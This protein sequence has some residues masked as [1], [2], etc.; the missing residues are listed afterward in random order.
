MRWNKM[1][2]KAIRN[3]V[4]EAISI[5]Q[6][7]FHAP[8]IGVP[9]TYLD[10]EVF[11]SDAPFLRNAPFISTMISNPNHIGVHTFE[12]H[13]ME[14][15]FAGT[16]A[17]EI[18]LIR[19]MAENM[20]KGGE[21][22]QDGYVAAGGTEANIQAQWIYR[23]YFIKERGAKIEEIA[24]VYSADSH[25]SMP[26]GANVLNLKSII[27]DV[28][29]N[30][31]QINQEDMH[32]KISTALE[33]GIK[34]FIV[35][36]NMST[37]MFGSVDDLDKICDYFNDQKLDYKLHVDGAFGGFIYPF[38]K[39]NSAYGFHNPNVSSITVDA[40]K[41]LQAPYGTGVFLCRKGLMEYTRTDE[42][43]YV[44]GLDFTLSG[45]RSGAN[46]VSVWM[47]MMVHGPAGLKVRMQNLADKAQTL[48]E[49]LEEMGVE[50]FQQEGINIVT[51]K[52]K[53]IVPTVAKKYRLV[54]DNY[55]GNAN[56]W[57]VVVMK[58]VTQG[59]LDQFVEDVRL[60]LSK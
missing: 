55:S 32:A 54:S 13:Q 47:I 8:I 29:F 41:M 5:N 28:D 27:L 2:N 23:N 26:K 39:E 7:Y 57:K 45:S 36:A 38:T 1:T 17:L 15:I 31:R 52:D 16:Q 58:H 11:Y 10:E 4:F 3:R 56:W 50:V 12:D 18:E 20:F 14:D 30:D 46:A 6:S 19:V 9:A 22:E 60:S 40:H 25:Y 53:Y 21:K 35:V 44:Q 59:T 34:H 42:A 48:K 49:D 24:I 37:T 51:I 33:D 43:S